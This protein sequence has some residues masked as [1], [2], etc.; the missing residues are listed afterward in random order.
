MSYHDNYADEVAAHSHDDD[1]DDDDDDANNYHNSQSYEV[2]LNERAMNS[3]LTAGL[4]LIYYFFLFVYLF[5]YLLLTLYH[6][7][8]VWRHT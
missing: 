8:V 2:A 6:H 5:I 3:L 4:A 1:D 7:T